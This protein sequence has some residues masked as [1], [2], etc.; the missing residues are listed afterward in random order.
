[1]KIGNKELNNPFEFYLIAEVG[2][3][4][5]GD[6]Q[7]A[8][9]LIRAAKRGGADAV[10]FQTYK[11]ELIA[12]KES[13]AYWDTSEE[14]TTNQFDLFKKYDSF[15]QEDYIHLFN[16][17]QKIGIDFA[18]TPFD[19]ESVDWLDTLVPF[20]KIASADITNFPLIRAI[21]SKNKP[22]LLST[23]ASTV[24]EIEATLSEI[25]RITSA[26][27]ILLHCI[28]NYPTENVN[29]NL[30]MI[31]DLK[32]KFP[33]NS[34]GYSDHTRSSDDMEVLTAAF[35]LGAQVIEKHFTL[36]KE[37]PGNDHYHA[38]DEENSRLFVEK[39]K[40]LR[41]IIGT[42][43]KNYLESEIPA[44]VNARRSLY[45]AKSLL[46]GSVIKESDLISLRPGHGISPTKIDEIVGKK[47]NKGVRAQ[48]Q[49][50]EVDFD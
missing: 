27:V 20:F 9:E 8:I 43:E 1:M 37:I 50:K 45:Y 29:A 38:M 13:P 48:D 11:A 21:A 25:A 17:C 18:S 7:T 46:E 47:L 42:S 31:S 32:V 30:N 2:V 19:L 28:L 6:I 5:G 26:P 34:I 44:R 4:H 10:K 33:T 23:G 41:S 49:V 14:V 35:T 22:I 24:Q 16:E 12:A 36:D 3:N 15:N 39:V 40:N